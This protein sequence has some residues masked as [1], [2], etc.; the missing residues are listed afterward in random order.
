[1]GWTLVEAGHPTHFCAANVAATHSSNTY[2]TVTIWVPFGVHGE[3]MPMQ[4]A[5]SIKIL[6]PNVD[7]FHVHNE[8]N[9]IFRVVRDVTDKPVVF[10]IHDWTSIR[11]GAPDP[12][13]TYA[14]DNADGFVVPSRGYLK[15]IRDLKPGKPSTLIYS[16]VPSCL[17]PTAQGPVLPGPVYE[18]GVKGKESNNS[19]QFPW[20]NWAE[21]TQAVACNL[22][23]GAKMH[24]YTA[25]PT[26]NLEDYKNEHLVMHPPQLYDGLLYHLSRHSAGIVGCPYPD[27][28]FTD[29]MPNKLFEYVA[30]GIPCLVINAPEAKQYV[31]QNHLGMG[32][33]DAS[34]VIPAIES[35]TGHRVKEDRWRFTMEGELPALLGFYEEVLRCSPVPRDISQAAV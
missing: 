33:R 16:K 2:N 4:L 34:E 12:E 21:F 27:P 9:W 28:A 6:E 32:I 5:N 13:E 3:I 30:A 14:L 11:N 18:G 31:E 10:D 35:L 29:S 15:K 20:R 7:I 26:E 19:V 17:F 24:V 22:Q 1:M 8:P 23:N 25:D